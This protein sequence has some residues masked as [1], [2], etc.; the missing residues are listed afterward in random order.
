MAAVSTKPA[1]LAISATA[2]VATPVEGAWLTASVADGVVT[3]SVNIA[4][5]AVGAYR[6]LITV[7]RP[8]HRRS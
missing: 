4:G 2:S 5:L 8:V 7:S 3:V 1:N 6:G